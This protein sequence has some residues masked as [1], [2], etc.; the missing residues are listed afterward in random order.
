MQSKYWPERRCDNQENVWI[1]ISRITNKREIIKYFPK[2]SNNEYKVSREAYVMKSLY[3]EDPKHFLKMIDFIDDYSED[4]YIIAMEKADC[5]LENLILKKKFFTEKEAIPIFKEILLGIE[6]MH[7]NNY[8]HRDLKLSNLLLMSKDDYSSIKI[9]DFGETIERPDVYKASGLVGTTNYMAPEILK[10]KKYGKSVDIWSF[11]IVAYRLLTGSFPYC[12]NSDN[13]S[14]HYK[15]IKST[16]LS[17]IRI[18]GKK[19][20]PK[21]IDF[22]NCF[23]V[24]EPEKRISI[25][26]ALNH[27][28]LNNETNEEFIPMAPPTQNISKNKDKENQTHMKNYIK[29]AIS[30]E[31]MEETKKKLKNFVT[32]SSKG[33]K[34][35]DKNKDKSNK[36]KE[37]SSLEV[38]KFFGF[39]KS[40]KNKIKHLSFEIGKSSETPIDQEIS[41]K[42]MAKSLPR[43]G[44][45]TSETKNIGLMYKPSQHYS[46][47]NS[48][49]T[50]VENQNNNF[51][52]SNSLNN[53][54]T[55]ENINVNKTEYASNFSSNS[56]NITNNISYNTYTTTKNE[57]EDISEE[58]NKYHN[59]NSSQTK[60]L[61]NINNQYINNN[62]S[63]NENK[64]N[65]LIKADNNNNNT[66][67]TITIN[68]K[69]A[70]N[71]FNNN[72]NEVKDNKNLLNFESSYE[73][74]S[75]TISKS[76]G[77]VLLNTKKNED[78]VNTGKTTYNDN[79]DSNILKNEIS[80]GNS[81]IP[82]MTTAGKYNNESNST[83]I[84]KKSIEIASMKSNEYI[85]I[86]SQINNDKENNEKSPTFKASEARSKSPISRP[87]SQNSRLNQIRPKSPISLYKPIEVG[88]PKS[89]LSQPST[90]LEINNP[91]FKPKIN[92][93]NLSMTQNIKSNDKNVK[94]S[95]SPLS[96]SFNNQN[97]I[98]NHEN[99]KNEINITTNTTSKDLNKALNDNENINKPIK[100]L[101]TSSE[102]KE[103]IDNKFKIN[104]TI[105]DINLKIKTTKNI[106]KILK[107][108][109]NVPARNSSLRN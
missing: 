29:N 16:I 71:I 44:L 60:E 36:H 45:K 79:I 91:N 89:P 88:K 105:K 99:N 20:S 27:P 101:P 61:I 107:I 37:K 42:P 30:K 82:I 109:P 70:N 15:V 28:F 53:N 2:E 1:A 75:P 84:E 72:T 50:T 17:Y 12:S 33:E 40:N 59:I 52:F 10:K 56:N 65:D 67:I 58:I 9:I 90:T 104:K 14:K 106:T 62:Y 22:I 93:S 26:N 85:E 94:P 76:T 48:S 13:Y 38:P 11:G 5:S 46:N 57:N 55:N 80:H 64:I 25:S 98:S 73:K 6:V 100:I 21:A 49:H 24:L 43:N 35:N 69:E 8:I 19:L 63:Y 68:G 108:N 102:N 3:N 86:S 54:M 92:K 95:S 47:I 7:K 32:N 18:D 66:E 81:R 34:S 31:S 78:K 41:S 4:Q 97:D 103:K 51:D 74:E 23:L 77:N 96:K 87:E 39:N 83:G